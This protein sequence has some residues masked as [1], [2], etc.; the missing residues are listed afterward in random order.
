[1]NTS[2]YDFV[3]ILRDSGDRLTATV[4]F[5]RR[6]FADEG[7]TGRVGFYG[8]ADQGRSWVLLNA[9]D[10]QLDDIEVC[11][12]FDVTLIDA[13]RATKDAAEVERISEVGRRTCAIAADTI[14]FLRAH[15]VLEVGEERRHVFGRIEAGKQ[16]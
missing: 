8:L 6:I 9:L 12:E 13:A 4:E 7:V 5:Y 11:A 15:G 3:T 1:M 10:S 14:E 16:A 2:K